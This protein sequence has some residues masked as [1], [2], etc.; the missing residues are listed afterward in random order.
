MVSPAASDPRSRVHA[1]WNCIID[2]G[3][4][5]P[6]KRRTMQQL[7]VS[8]R[9]TEENRRACKK[10]FERTS[11]VVEDSLAAR[12]EPSRADFYINTVMMGL[13]DLTIDAIAA[14][15]AR[16][17]HLKLAGFDFFWNGIAA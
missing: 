14:D 2:W 15:P 4:D 1:I 17:D 13:A 11:E 5:N 10:L 16:K 9:I 12:I 7:L 3:F 8:D 6:A